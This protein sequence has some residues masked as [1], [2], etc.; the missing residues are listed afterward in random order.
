MLF[1]TSPLIFAGDGQIKALIA[2]TR[3]NAGSLCCV[4]VGALRRCRGRSL[5]AQVSVVADMSVRVHCGEER[6]NGKE[7]VKEQVTGRTRGCAYDSDEL[8]PG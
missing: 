1:G 2:F 6:T 8:N 3:K 4:R 5:G 7:T